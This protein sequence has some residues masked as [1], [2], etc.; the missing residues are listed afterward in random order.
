VVPNIAT[1]TSTQNPTPIPS[2]TL[3][4]EVCAPRFD[5]TKAADRATYSEGDVVTW[6]VR[7]SNQGGA[8]ATGV[9]VSD[10]VDV[11]RLDESTL[12]F[13]P[14][15]GTWNTST[16][17]YTWPAIGS[18]AGNGTQTV[19]FSI[20]GQLK[21]GT[22]G[23]RICDT[24]QLIADQTTSPVL[25][26]PTTGTC[27]DIAP[28]ACDPASFPSPGPIQAVRSGSDVVFSWPALSPAPVEYH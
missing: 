3:E 15:T 23:Q 21:P 20:S 2:Q 4:V 19:I 7:L 28:P 5:F 18:L 24:A 22:N 16:K 27:S 12:V 10:N 17:T 9:V 11:F 8:P 25:S 6:T 13:T 1:A 14:A 26:S